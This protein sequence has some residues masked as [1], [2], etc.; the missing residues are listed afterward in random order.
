M[1]GPL[2]AR[3]VPP[4]VKDARHST[5]AQSFNSPV[6]EDSPAVRSSTR[7]APLY[8]RY[9]PSNLPTTAEVSSRDNVFEKN[10]PDHS[11]ERQAQWVS[12]G[13]Y[14]R[15]QSGE[16][17][18]EK[19]KTYRDG[20]ETKRRKDEPEAAILLESTGVNSNTVHTERLDEGESTESIGRYV[21]ESPEPSKKRQKREDA[22]KEESSEDDS[23]LKRHKTIL[24]KYE[25]SFK[26]ATV[27]R[28]TATVQSHEQSKDAHVELH[29]VFLYE[30]DAGHELIDY[31]PGAS[32]PAFASS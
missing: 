29:G 18:K 25:K 15:A 7:A 26:I 16:H 27:L 4:R 13:A 24:S 10:Q 8:A 23:Q 14:R 21:S 20:D 31:R 12:N 1:A 28:Q 19:Q 32:P 6:D 11:V 30:S 9:I 17:K 3:Y 22:R 5:S 2:Y